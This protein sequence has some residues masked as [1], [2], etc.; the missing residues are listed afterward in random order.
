MSVHKHRNKWQV[1]VRDRNG[2]WYPT[3]TFK[4]K[5]DAKRYNRQLE[6]LKD[7]GQRAPSSQARNITMDISW[8]G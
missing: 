7:E 5:E 4:R 2:K 3:K 6:R 1:R 8:V